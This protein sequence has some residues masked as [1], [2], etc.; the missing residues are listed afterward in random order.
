M[1]LAGYNDPYDVLPVAQAEVGARVTYLRRLGMMTLGSLGITTIA[2]LI[3]IGAIL[4]IPALSN[5]WVSIALMLGGIYG[6]Q[7]V[8]GSMVSSPDAGTRTAGF[9]IGSSLSGMALGYLLLSAAVLGMAQFG[10]PLVF[11]GQAGTLV[12]LTVVGMVVYL[13]SGPRE[14]SMVGSMLS[15][16]T[17]PMLGL[18]VITWA[19]PV[20]GIMGDPV[21]GRLRG[22]VRRRPAV[23]P[24]PGDAPDEHRHGDG[25]SVSR[26]PGDRDPVLEH[27]DPV[28]APAAR[29]IR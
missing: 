20:G 17:L 5:T 6:A 19:F 15:M 9:V 1:A 8:G 22:G 13:M 7:F 11:I 3:S 27:P 26:L 21:L 18:M 14:L 12:F 16:L 29:L 10:N 4:M 2:A 24:Q 23:Q 25:R 28:D